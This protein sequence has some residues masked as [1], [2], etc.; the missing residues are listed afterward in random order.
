[1]VMVWVSSLFAIVIVCSKVI[2]LFS[3]EVGIPYVESACAKSD[4]L[5]AVNICFSVNAQF[6]YQ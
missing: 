4:H 3:V 5:S 6:L 2:S 1:M